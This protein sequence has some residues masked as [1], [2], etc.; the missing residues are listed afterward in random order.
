MGTKALLSAE[1]FLKLPPVDGKRYELDEGELVEMTFPNVRH[2]RIA[3]RIYRL[4]CGWLDEHPM[5]EAFPSDQ[6]YQLSP[7]TVRGPDVSFLRAGRAG[8]LNEEADAIDGAPDLAVEVVSPSDRPRQV[9]RKV[10]QYLSAGCHT[11]WAVYPETREVHAFTS[12][13]VTRLSGKDALTCPELLGG[14]KAP[15]DRLFSPI[16]ELE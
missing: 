7:D 2:N 9:Q 11:V 4:L 10:Q 16:V 15:V 5:G 8:K 3:G 6:G 12:A 13:G 14:F 1:K